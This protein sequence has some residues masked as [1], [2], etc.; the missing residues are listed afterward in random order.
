VEAKISKVIG[1]QWLR[2]D[3]IC[4]G[5]FPRGLGAPDRYVTVADGGFPVLRVDVYAYPQDCFP[6]EDV[7]V[8]HDNV[9]I[10]FG[11][12]AHVVA[13]A[14]HESCTVALE[15]YFGHL[16]PTP[17]YLLIASGE[18]LFRMDPDRTIL[19]TSDFL[20]IDG[21]VVDDA[22]P[23][24]IRGQAEQD[25]PGGWEPFAVSATDGRAVR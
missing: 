22:G 24:M 2:L 14:N 20:A 23:P 13:I 1:D 3:P 8:W 9:V 19:W 11:S 6:F 5:G 17:D 12:H 16:Y 7:L 15:S 10:G 25:P 4:V 21:I 18:R